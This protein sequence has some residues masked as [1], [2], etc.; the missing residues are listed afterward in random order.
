MHILNETLCRR[1]DDG[2]KEY[3]ARGVTSN[4]EAYV[5]AHDGPRCEMNAERMKAR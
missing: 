2:C 1:S 3:K 4:V 5:E